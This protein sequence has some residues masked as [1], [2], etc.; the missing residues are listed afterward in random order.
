M[1]EWNMVKYTSLEI[2]DG[3]TVYFDECER[4][5]IYI[6]FYIPSLLFL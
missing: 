5:G 3:A 1:C 4:K 2:H 6:L